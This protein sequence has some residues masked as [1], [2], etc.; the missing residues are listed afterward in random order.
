[1]MLPGFRATVKGTLTAGIS[2][3]AFCYAMS[4]PELAY[5]ATLPTR[6]A[7]VRLRCCYAMCGTELAYGG[8]RCA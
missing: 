8:V 1:M 3:R 5:G 6:P 4:G 7:Q 2:L